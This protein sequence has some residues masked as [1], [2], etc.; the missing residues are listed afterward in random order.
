MRES[1]I[2]YESGGAWVHA[3][4]KKS[5]YVVYETKMCHYSESR[6]AFALNEDGLSI[7]I[8]YADY[9]SNKQGNK[10]EKQ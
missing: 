1:E 9:I 8:V 3:D 4:K 10:N 6:A 7:A 5:L 2:V